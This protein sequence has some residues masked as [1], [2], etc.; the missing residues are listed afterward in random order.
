MLHWVMPQRRLSF[1]VK[2]CV[3]HRHSRNFTVGCMN[4]SIECTAGK[5]NH[6]ISLECSSFDTISSALKKSVKRALII[7]RYTSTRK[8]HVFGAV[9][10]LVLSEE[11]TRFYPSNVAV[12]VYSLDRLIACPTVSTKTF[13]STWRAKYTPAVVCFV[14]TAHALALDSRE[15]AGRPLT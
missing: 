5:L 11:Q 1:W 10:S 12:E 15:H 4:W 14:W 7:Y 8:E 13:I 3:R 9:S 6:K 2:S